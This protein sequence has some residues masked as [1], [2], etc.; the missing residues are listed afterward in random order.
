MNLHLIGNL[1]NKIFNVKVKSN[2]FYFILFYFIKRYLQDYMD[3]KET[4][5]HILKEYL[6]ELTPFEYY[7]EPAKYPLINLAKFKK[8]RWYKFEEINRRKRRVQYHIIP[9]KYTSPF[10]KFNNL[11]KNL[12]YQQK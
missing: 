1:E 8:P 11:I 3:K 12:P 10:D 2:H 4:N 5:E 7:S 6:K 9:F